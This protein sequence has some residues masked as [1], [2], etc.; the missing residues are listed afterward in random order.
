MRP[1]T[2]T[3][4]GRQA[5]ASQKFELS[6][7]APRAVEVCGLVFQPV[8]NASS[9]RF[10]DKASRFIELRGQS[11][12]G[13]GGSHLGMGDCRCGV[14]CLA[15]HFVYAQMAEVRQQSGSGLSNPGTYV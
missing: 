9:F 14:I 15:D 7:V 13:S 3:T 10:G 5:L 6:L 8:A 1:L 12:G 11:S 4:E 2:T